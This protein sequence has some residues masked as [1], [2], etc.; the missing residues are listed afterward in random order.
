VKFLK[1]ENITILWF[2]ETSGWFYEENE[3][4]KAEKKK[5]YYDNNTEEFF[6]SRL[7]A[8]AKENNGFMAAKKT[9]WADIWLVGTFGYCNY[10]AGRDLI[11][12]YPNLKKVYDNTMAI[13]Q[14]KKWVETRPKTYA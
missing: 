4:T 11:A 2:S 9:T 5:I 7:D 6:L 8:I 13:P 3:Q 14:I 10:L 1:F 12:N